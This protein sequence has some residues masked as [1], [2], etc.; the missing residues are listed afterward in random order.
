MAAHGRLLPDQG[1]EAPVVI[2]CYVCLLDSAGDDDIQVH[3]APLP[4][5]HV[6]FVL[7]C[8]Y[9]LFIVNDYYYQYYY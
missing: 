8:C 5:F 1:E 9:M 2:S 6:M 7:F 4:L 3:D